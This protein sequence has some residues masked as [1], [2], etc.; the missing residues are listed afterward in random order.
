MMLLQALDYSNRSSEA[1]LL[2][3]GGAS[4]VRLGGGAEVR[5]LWPGLRTPFRFRLGLEVGVGVGA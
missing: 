3:L 1:K 5:K 4:Q 2:G